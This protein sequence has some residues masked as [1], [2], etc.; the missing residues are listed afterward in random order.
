MDYGSPEWLQRTVILTQ[1]AVTLSLAASQ[2]SPNYRM[3]LFRHPW[4]SA[5]VLKN[6]GGP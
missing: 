5:C 6:S 3:L 2:L 1:P 4:H